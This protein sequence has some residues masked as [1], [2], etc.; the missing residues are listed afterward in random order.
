MTTTSHCQSTGRIGKGEIS[1]ES[2]WQRYASFSCHIYWLLNNHTTWSMCNRPRTASIH[3]LDDDSILHVF[4]LSRPFFGDRD[5]PADWRYKGRWWYALAHVCR[6]WRNIILGSASYLGLS[7]LCTYGTPVAD[8]LA[9]SPPLPLV[10][11]YFTKNRSLTTEDEEGIILALK[12]RDRVHRV[13]F[14]KAIMQKL[15]VADRKSVV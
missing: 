14:G 15:F 5:G 11:G 12:Q 7:L 10:L 6:R 1:S 13:R 3:T 4:H 8:M 9:H 2:R